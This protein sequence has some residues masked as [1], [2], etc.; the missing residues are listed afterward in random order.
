MNSNQIYLEWVVNFKAN[1]YDTN[2]SLNHA[3][4]ET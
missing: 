4:I 3:G 1:A 2:H